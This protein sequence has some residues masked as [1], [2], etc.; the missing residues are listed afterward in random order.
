MKSIQNIWDKTV[1]TLSGSLSETV[2]KLWIKTVYPLKYENDY[3]ILVVE[4]TIQQTIIIS[5]YK[6]IIEDVLSSIVGFDM[7][8]SVVLDKKIYE[9]IKKHSENPLPEEEPQEELVS[10]NDEEYTFDNFIVG[11]SNQ[12][13]H[14]S[15]VAVAKH[16]ATMY[17]PL[18]IYGNTGLGKTHLLNAIKNEILKN[19]PSFRI[20]YVSSEEFINDVI[21]NIQNRTMSDIRNKYRTLDVLLVDDIQFIAGKNSTQEEFFHTFETLYHAKKQIILASDR[22]PKDIQLL[23]SRLRSRFES[24]VITDISA[25]DLELKVAIIRKKCA[26]YNIKLSDEIE[27]FIADKIKNNIRQLEGVIKKLVSTQLIMKDT[28]TIAIAQSAISEVTNENEPI[29]ITIEKVLTTVSKHYEVSVSDIK[30]KKRTG[31]IVFARQISMYILREITDLSLP[32]IGDIFGGNGEKG[33]NHSTVHHA[34]KKVE[35]KFEYSPSA[36]TEVNKLIE[37]IRSM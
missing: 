13:A 15:C 5:K 29:D 33:K 11:S 17:N 28:P 16:P 20:L 4:N 31:N 14:A 37:D 21:E 9:N 18:F 30:S 3:F 8:I 10:M 35:E 2:M 6:D 23:E 7:K 22:P 32:D 19:N 27:F 34:I 25:P 24:G 12:H 36:K 1:E 26:A